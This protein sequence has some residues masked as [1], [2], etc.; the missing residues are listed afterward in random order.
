MLPDTPRR[1][2]LPVR[3][4]ITGG[5]PEAELAPQLPNSGF[6][7]QPPNSGGNVARQFAPQPPNS[8]GLLGWR[9]P[10]LG[11]AFAGRKFAGSLARLTWDAAPLRDE[12]AAELV[13]RVIEV[14]VHDRVVVERNAGYLGGRDAQTLGDSDFRVG[15]ALSQALFEGL[16]GGRLNE[17]QDRVGN[18]GPHDLRSL[19]LDLQHH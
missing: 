11:R 8:G 16:D 2:R 10:W 7:P 19:H 9:R 4:G 13:Q 18:D 5:A 1:I 3:S 6:A 15:A 17:D 12:N 14:V